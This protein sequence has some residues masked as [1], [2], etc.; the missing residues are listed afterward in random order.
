VN[1]SYAA[2][3]LAGAGLTLAVAVGA[4][5]LSTLLGIVAAAARLSSHRV[6]RG[7]A[8]AYATLIR[9]VPDLVLMLLIFYGGQIAVNAL[10][11]RFGWGGETGSIDIDP[12]VAGTITIGF[13][14]GAYFAETFRG[15]MLAVPVGQSE[16]ALACGMSRAQVLVR[17]VLPQMVRHALP[18]FTNNW[19][20]LVKSTAL[21]SVIGLTDLMY[22]AKQAGAATRAAFFYFMVAAAVYLAITSVSML[23]LRA[24]EHRHARGVR[25][26]AA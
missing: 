21:V 13:I 22:R 11:M 9:G 14:Y 5:A 18:G 10:A 1:T 12:F 3:V 7:I 2:Y 6:P 8:T 23:A 17:I 24:V 26:A 4:L 20:V 25:R 15:A 16:A 19:L